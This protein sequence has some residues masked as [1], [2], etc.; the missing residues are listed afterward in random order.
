MS[1]VEAKLGVSRDIVLSLSEFMARI[2]AGGNCVGIRIHYD[3]AARHLHVRPENFSDVH[4]RPGAHGFHRAY[5]SANS[6]WTKNR[7]L[8][9]VMRAQPVR[10]IKSLRHHLVL[11]IP[12]SSKVKPP[13]RVSR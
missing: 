10:V 2:F 12:H 3:A 1:S 5:F 13:R 8:L 9:P 11:E 7:H 4:I 6:R